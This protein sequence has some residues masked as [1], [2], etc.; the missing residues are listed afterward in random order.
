M[1]FPRLLPG[2]ETQ[3]TLMLA[4]AMWG[5]VAGT[6]TRPRF[7]FVLLAG[8]LGL[9]CLFRVSAGLGIVSS[10]LLFQ[11]LIGPLFFFG[12]VAF[13]SPPP[14]RATLRI[15]TLVLLAIAV[16]EIAA[17]S[18]YLSLGTALLDRVTVT[19][20]H[21]GVSFLTPEPTYA[22][23]SLVYLFLLTLW[24]RQNGDRRFAWIETLQCIL[25]MMTLS[26][27]TVI[28]L[29][30]LIICKWPRTSALAILAVV[31]LA[32]SLSAIST[33]G[34]QSLRFM[35]AITS[36]MATDFSTFLPSL[37]L[38]DTSLGSRLLT[39]AAS[40][41]TPGIAPLGL[42]MDCNAVPTAFDQ[43][44]YTF[45]FSNEVIRQVIADGCLKPQSYGAT[46][47]L[48]LGWMAFPFIAILSAT[49]Y[50]CRLRIQQMAL[51]K[52]AFA[53]AAVMLIVQAQ[54]T[55]PIPWMLLF[56]ASTRYAPRP[57]APVTPDLV[58]L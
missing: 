38:L 33:E 21:R 55:S 46:V 47:F 4:A 32:P 22:A 54:L 51:W 39:N 42:G 12:A 50:L 1:Y 36:L 44:E 49:A 40:F 13:R 28:F 43:L 17:P 45:A 23:I 27:Y 8:A 52:P 29:L 24:S 48:G 30:I 58:P 57:P 37:S 53:I 31:V 7:F 3:P 35:V 25:L 16:F 2:V 20:G 18:L 56:L 19:D 11:L 26:T 6:N 41:Q 14:S 15:V 5:L 34:A 9:L 10:L